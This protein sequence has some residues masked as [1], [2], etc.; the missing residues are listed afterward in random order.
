MDL[1]DKVALITGGKRIGAAVALALAAR[2]T[3]V[4]LSYSRSRAEADQAADRIRATGRRAETIQAD[5]SQPVAC[6]ALISGVDGAFGGIDILINMASVYVSKPFDQLTV[7][8][9]NANADVDLRS[10]FSKAALPRQ[11][12]CMRLTGRRAHHRSQRLGV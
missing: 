1:T 7:A 9:W 2:G 5:L 4:A 6:D 3:D 11:Q 10:A 12:P 8:D